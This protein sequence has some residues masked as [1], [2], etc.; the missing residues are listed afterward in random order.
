LQ[1]PKIFHVNWFR[2]DANGDFLW[3]G[4]GQ[5]IRVIDWIL[6]RLDGDESIGQKTAIGIV[7]KDGSLNLEG[8]ENIDMKEL[9]SVP[10]QYWQEDVAEVRKFMDE[11]VGPDLPKEVRAEMERQFE[12]IAAL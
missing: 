4:Y 12:R 9:M 7:P 1:V 8:L 10:K 11:Q 5:N 2:R 3:P 6:R